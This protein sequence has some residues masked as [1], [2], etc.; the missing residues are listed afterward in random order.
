MEED[1]D[2]VVTSD[3]IDGDGNKGVL[4]CGLIGGASN[5]GC[6]GGGGGG[7]GGGGDPNDELIAVEVDAFKMYLILSSFLFLKRLGL[8]INNIDSHG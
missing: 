1:E 3:D 2:E 6:D 5:V 8:V 7:G 4:I